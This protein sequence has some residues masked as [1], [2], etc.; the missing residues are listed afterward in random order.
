MLLRGMSSDAIK[1]Y[2]REKKGMNTLWEDAM[3]KCVAGLTTLEEV[4]R[5]TTND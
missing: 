3:G 4:M 2:A 5:I 1:Q